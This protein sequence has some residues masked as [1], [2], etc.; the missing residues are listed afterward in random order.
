MY[1]V[2]TAYIAKNMLV[3]KME[4]ADETGYVNVSVFTALGALPV[5]NAKVSIYTWNEEEG[6]TLIRSVTTNESGSAPAIELPVLL[7]QGISSPEGHTEYH[8]AV[9]AE[10]YHTVIIINVEVYPDIRN[11]FN[12]NLTPIPRG[13]QGGE[14]TVNIPIQIKNNSRR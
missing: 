4:T 10:V 3:K 12:V 14:E 13:E 6:E 2:T 11:Q 5:S 7:G 9:E 8:L 1:K